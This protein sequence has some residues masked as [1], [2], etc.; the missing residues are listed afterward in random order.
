VTYF[1]PIV[2]HAFKKQEATLTEIAK[3]E[4]LQCVL[5]ACDFPESADEFQ[6]QAFGVFRLWLMATYKKADEENEEIKAMR[7]LTTN[8]KNHG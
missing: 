4:I 7:D 5:D 6:A 1:S 8:W 2:A 3:E